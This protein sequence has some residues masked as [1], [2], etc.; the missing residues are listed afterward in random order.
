MQIILLVSVS[1]LCA[2][3]G[4]ATTEC[5]F[6]HSSVPLE[7]AQPVRRFVEAADVESVN[8]K[9][10]A[11][12]DRPGKSGLLR[13]RI[14]CWLMTLKHENACHLALDKKS[15]ASCWVH[16]CHWPRHTPTGCKEGPA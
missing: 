16:V 10:R 5:P 3:A 1:V 12:I 7:D 9:V 13:G 15:P 8:W 6:K 4:P 11:P 14:V 2:L